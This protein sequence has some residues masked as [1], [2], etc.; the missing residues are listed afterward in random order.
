MKCV[1]C[2]MATTVKGKTTIT[3]DRDNTT[4]LVKSVPANI[5]QNCGEEYLDE[6]TTNRLLKLASQAVEAGVQIDIRKYKAA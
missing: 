6:K 3:L 1:I 2:K 5:C 4:L